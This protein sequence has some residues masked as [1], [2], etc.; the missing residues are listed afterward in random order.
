VLC[1]CVCVCVCDDDVR[2][3]DDNMYTHTGE[4]LVVGH[5]MGHIVYWNV[6]K[7]AHMKVIKPDPLK[8]RTHTHTHTHKKIKLSSPVTL[9]RYT[10]P[11][12]HEFIAINEQGTVNLM[13]VSRMF[14]SYSM[15]CVHAHTHIHTHIRTHTHTRTY[16]R[17]YDLMKYECVMF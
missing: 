12:A 13:C 9:L 3:C 6:L 1:V 17:T 11:N 16:I 4:Y 2:V 15:R 10:R 7:K 8:K 14:F 5:E